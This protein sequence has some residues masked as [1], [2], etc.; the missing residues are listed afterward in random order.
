M[1]N[2]ILNT[3]DKQKIS[4]VHYSRGFPKAVVLCHGFFNNKDV[5]LFKAMSLCLSE[6]YDVFAFDFRGHGKSSGLFSWTARESADLDAVLGQV[7]TFHYDSIGLIGFSLGAA[8]SL[9]QAARDPDISTV[10]AVSAPFEFWEIDFHFWKPGMW[11]DL[12]LNLGY[13][14]RGKGV[15]PGNLFENKVAAISIVDRISPRPVLFIHGEK[16]WLIKARHSQRLYDQARDPKRLLVI[17]GGG[18]AEML[19]D[20]FPD[21]FMGECLSWLDA[22]L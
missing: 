10:I 14:G 16:D 12:K 21:L 13:K 19:Y 17:P 8:L 2:L 15:R 3:R 9:S 4:A 22:N 5:H 11:D 18:H 20:E 6:H 7:R 1:Q